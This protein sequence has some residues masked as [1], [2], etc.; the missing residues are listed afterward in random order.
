V[1][2]GL[3]LLRKPELRILAGLALATTLAARPSP[4]KHFVEPSCRASW[5]S[6]TNH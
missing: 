4:S 3:I 2:A 1:S 6:T 5:S